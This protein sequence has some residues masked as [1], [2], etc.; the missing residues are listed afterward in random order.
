MQSVIWLYARHVRLL[1]YTV[2]VL[3]S[4]EQASHSPQKIDSPFVFLQLSHN[5]QT[6]KVKNVRSCSLFYEYD[7]HD[8]VYSEVAMSL[9]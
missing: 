5:E 6:L 3:R 8:A 7:V 9:C 1:R 2:H 4:G